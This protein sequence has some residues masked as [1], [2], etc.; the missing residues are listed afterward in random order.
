MGSGMELW[1]VQRNTP[2][3]GFA[4]LETTAQERKQIISLLK[5]EL[6]EQSQASQAAG[7]QLPLSRAHSE[8]HSEDSLA[9]VSSDAD[10][11]LRSL[12]L[13]VSV[14]VSE[15]LCLQAS[16]VF[17]RQRKK[18]SNIPRREFG[19]GQGRGPEPLPAG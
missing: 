19:S 13:Y 5:E 6:W 18:K 9:E 10:L 7:P 16:H 12:L 11:H 17:T 15:A 2:L 4:S 14:V 1:P 8:L 3:P